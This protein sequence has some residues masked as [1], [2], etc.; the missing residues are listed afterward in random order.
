MLMA[1]LL[2]HQDEAQDVG[3]HGVIVFIVA[4]QEVESLKKKG[5]CHAKEVVD[6]ARECEL[7]CEAHN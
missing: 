1:V 4:V 5:L 7:W 2:L 6:V 3:S